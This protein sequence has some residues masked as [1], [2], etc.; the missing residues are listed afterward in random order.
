MAEAWAADEAT[1]RR[2]TASKWLA[3]R[4]VSSVIADALQLPPLTTDPHSQ[5]SYVK[6]LQRPQVEQLRRPAWA[7]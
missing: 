5:F 2:W 6:K 7:A 1:G 3:S 4:N